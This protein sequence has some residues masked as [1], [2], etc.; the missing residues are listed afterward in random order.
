MTTIYLDTSAFL[1][2]YLTESGST[3]LKNYIIGKQVY[4]SKLVLVESLTSLGRLY[5]QGILTRTDAEAISDHI[6]QDRPKYRLV[7]FITYAQIDRVENLVFT[8]PTNIYLRALDAIHLATAIGV[9]NPNEPFVF[10]SADAQLLRA[11]TV[12]GL[13]VE[14]PETYN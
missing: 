12:H 11:A 1:K 5:R 4:I 14:N 2:L 6:D 7:Q 8:L 3:W 9:R 10:V 13:S